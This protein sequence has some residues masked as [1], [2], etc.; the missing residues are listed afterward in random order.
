M[1]SKAREESID[2]VKAQLPKEQ[3]LLSKQCPYNTVCAEQPWV[4]GPLCLRGLKTHSF[5]WTSYLGFFQHEQHQI[6]SSIIQMRYVFK[7]LWESI[8]KHKVPQKPWGL[9]AGSQSLAFSHIIVP[10]V[11]Q[12][13]HCMEKA[14]TLWKFH[15]SQCCDAHI[16]L[17]QLNN[18]ISLWMKPECLITVAYQLLKLK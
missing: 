16:F 11:C 8:T 3:S 17:K 14:V 4:W 1:C 6:K 7:Y 2:L 9:L 10:T 15:L 5:Q 12:A 18:S 13:L